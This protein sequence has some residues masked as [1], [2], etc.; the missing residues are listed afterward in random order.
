M[1]RVL[2]TFAFAVT[3]LAGTGTAAWAAQPAPAPSPSA[4][5]TATP[6]AS[7]SASA[8]ASLDPN[9]A[10]VCAK[11]R[12]TMTKGIE[13]FTKEIEKAGTLAS[14]GNL[15]GAEESVKKSG[16]VLID[17]GKKLRTDAEASQNRELTE[18]LED[19]AEELESLGGDLTSLASLQNFDTQR[20]EMLAERVAEI[21]GGS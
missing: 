14:S 15:V 2:T 10:E 6:S 20:L 13:D 4:S 3:F 7:P 12:E 8:S 19:V 1:K 16:T 9:T 21:C 18:A 11:S 17:L 5:A